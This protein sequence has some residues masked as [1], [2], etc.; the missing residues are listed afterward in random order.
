MIFA[1]QLPNNPTGQSKQ[2]L[3]NATSQKGRN[4]HDLLTD[5]SKAIKRDNR[6]AP[7]RVSGHPSLRPSLH[8]L[9]TVLRSAG[10]GGLRRSYDLFRGNTQ[11]AA[12][13]GDCGTHEAGTFAIRRLAERAGIESDSQLTATATANKLARITSPCCREKKIL[14]PRCSNTRIIARCKGCEHL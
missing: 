14:S 6:L 8:R 1:S 4:V 11:L 7:C 2:D 3:R 9:V 5:C 10:A 12:G 13:R